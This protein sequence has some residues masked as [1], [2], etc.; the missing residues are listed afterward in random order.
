MLDIHFLRFANALLEPVWNREHVAAVQVTLAEDF[1]VE[2]RGAFYDS[3]GALR[4]VVQNHL[5]QV[6]ALIA[7]EAPV[8][9]GHRSLWDKKVEV[10]RAMARRRPGTLRSRPVPGVPQ[11]SGCACWFGH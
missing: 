7:M 3:V 6:L 10:F 8:T 2:D 9:P 1:G 5:L 4:D 11:H